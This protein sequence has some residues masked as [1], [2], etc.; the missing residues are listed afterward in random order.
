M[1]A[2]WYVLSLISLLFMGTQRFLYKVSAEKK[3][4]AAWTT[5]SFMAT[6]SILSWILFF[7]FDQSVQD[8]KFLLFI[9]FLNSS[10]FAFGT[11]THIE[12]LK[13]IAV[14]VAYPIIR[15][16]VVVVVIFSILFFNDQPSF[17]QVIGII[18]AMAVIA[19]LTMHTDSQKLSYT[20]TRRGYILVFISFL[21][22]SVASISSKFAAMYTNKIGF[23]AT[24][25]LIG[26]LFSFGLAKNLETGQENPKHRDAL[27]IGVAMGLINFVGFY[28]FLKALAIGPL[29]IIVSIAG[30]HFVIAIL[31]SALI[32]KEK[33]APLRVV[34]IALSI[35]AIFLLRL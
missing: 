5:F 3:C 11:I 19:I 29:S 27:I 35:V 32:Y 10:T 12:A 30:M 8:V 21:C 2:N 20:N 13:H 1:E 22:G 6:V 7:L 18:S 33:L 4:N 25:Y 28:A 31:L 17:Y 34:G 16:N 26:T 24:S 15:L 9:A 23:M 14:S